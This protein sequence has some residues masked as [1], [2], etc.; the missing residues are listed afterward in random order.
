MYHSLAVR[1]DGTVV[2]WGDNAQGQSSVLVG[3][4]DVVA[5]AGGGGHSLA[6]RADGTVAAWG[7][8]WDGQCNPPFGLSDVVALGAGGYHSLALRAG[9][10]PIPRLLNPA[11]Q[12]GQFSVVLQTLNRKQYALEFKDSMSATNWS[13]VVTNAG[14]GALRLLTDPAATAAQRFYRMRQW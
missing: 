7:A 4:S 8:N 5:V 10:L 2:A 12:G 1:S 3:L 11:R 6:L 14:N 9:D 13:S